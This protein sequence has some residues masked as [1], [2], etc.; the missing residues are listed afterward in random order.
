MPGPGSVFKELK[1]SKEA[2]ANRCLWKTEG[3]GEMGHYLI[4][5]HRLHPIQ[6]ED[7][8]EEGRLQEDGESQLNLQDKKQRLSLS[9]IKGWG[10]ESEVTSI[11]INITQWAGYSSSHL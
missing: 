7:T 11:R 6:E 1:S 5:Q 4:R 10:E 2:L 9:E 3:Q 8:G